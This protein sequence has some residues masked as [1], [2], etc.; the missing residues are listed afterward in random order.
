[1]AE[2]VLFKI[3]DDISD[4][5]HQFFAHKDLNFF[6][7]V[8]VYPDGKYTFLCTKHDWPKD[9]I[10][11]N[12]PPVGFT[13][14][15]T[16][17]DGVRFPNMNRG[18]DF[19][20]SDDVT[21]SAKEQFN[22]QNPMIVFHKFAD[23]YEGFFF[24]LH[25]QN[26]YEKY[27]TQFDYFEKFIHYFK[28]RSK[29]LSQKVMHEPL[30]VDQKYLEPHIAQTTIPTHHNDSLISTL[31]DLRPRKYFLK[32]QGK[33]VVLS[34]KEYASLSEWSRGKTMKQIAEELKISPRTVE[35][36]L[37]RIL[38]KLNL[39]TKNQLISVYWDNRLLS[40]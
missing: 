26:V 16:I 40:Q 23:H 25:C 14:Y 31:D 5:S 38:E 37:L 20:W 32:Y 39:N 21:R 19:G 35:T 6:G 3:I 33:E 1:M 15:N 28:D 9:F 13:Q 11:K 22:I 27:L 2:N 17:S 24:D 30:I 36:Y 8:I 7:H 10:E 29:K 18:S 4:I 12:V 34:A